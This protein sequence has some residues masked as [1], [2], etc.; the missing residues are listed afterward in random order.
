MK[1]LVLCLFAV[2]AC[3][4]L[5]A[6]VTGPDGRNHVHLYGY[7]VQNTASGAGGF[8][9]LYLPS[10]QDMVRLDYPDNAS[11][12]ADLLNFQ[13]QWVVID[14]ELDGVSGCFDGVDTIV[15]PRVIY[16]WQRQ[17]QTW[18]IYDHDAQEWLPWP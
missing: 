18:E 9:T 16:R 14:A 10:A 6:G 11:G 5:S 4:P 7:V 17:T 1:R 3:L 8:L 15:V 13:E 12:A 2:L